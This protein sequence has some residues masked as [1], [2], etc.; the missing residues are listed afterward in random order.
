MFTF[1]I[2]GLHGLPCPPLEPQILEEARRPRFQR[3]K[4]QAVRVASEILGSLAPIRRN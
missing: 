4:V 2:M 3:A 1:M